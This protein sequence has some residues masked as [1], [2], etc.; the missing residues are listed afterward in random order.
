MSLATFNFVCTRGHVF[1][2]PDVTGDYGEFVLRGEESPVPARLQAVGNAP[3]TEVRKILRDLGAFRGKTDHQQANLLQAIFGI[4]CDPA[5]DGTRLTLG[6]RAPCP[7][8][9]TRKMASWEVVGPY[10]GPSLPITHE[11]WNA[12]SET[13]KTAR[14]AEA[15]GLP[16]L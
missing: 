8:C 10:N 15:V 3:Y 6:R 5:P 1:E 7:V 4:A 14:V 2:A 9:G 11:K 12:L 13:E 16:K